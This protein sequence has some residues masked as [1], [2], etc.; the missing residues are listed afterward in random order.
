M[1]GVRE[2][3]IRYFSSNRNADC[4]VTRKIFSEFIVASGISS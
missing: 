4:R 3:L 2:H 1:A